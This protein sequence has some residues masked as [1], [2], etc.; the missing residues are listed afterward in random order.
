MAYPVSFASGKGGTGKTTVVANLGAG[1]AKLGKDVIVLDADVTMADLG[2]VFNLDERFSLHEVLAGKRKPSDAIYD[3]G[4]GLKVLQGA[5][6][7]KE[8]QKIR[9]DRLKW[10]VRELTR[11]TEYLLVDCPSGFERDFVT[12][13]GSTTHLV[14]VVNPDFPSLLEAMKVKRVAERLHIR[15]VGV[16][17]NRTLGKGIDIPPNEIE[18]IL[19]LPIMGSIPE[20]IEVK[21]ALAMGTLVILHRPK[22]PAAK[23]FE[24]LAR[25]FVKK[26]KAL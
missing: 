12:A 7:L 16:V 5:L 24:R 15:P 1:I 11:K 13:L 20:D 10:V 8:I 17:V 25:S 4:D 3:V 6:S 2:L 18:S 26:F 9:L 21:R 14:L 19:E 23:A 22:S